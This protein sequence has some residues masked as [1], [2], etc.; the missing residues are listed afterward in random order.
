MFWPFKMFGGNQKGFTI[1]SLL[2]GLAITSI[3]GIGVAMATV[4]IM[5]SPSRVTEQKAV[6][7]TRIETV[8]TGVSTEAPP[9]R[10]QGLPQVDYAIIALNGDVTFGGSSVIKSD[11]AT[12]AE[13]DIYANGNITASGSSMAYGDADYTGTLTGESHIT[14]TKT[15]LSTALKFPQIQQSVYAARSALIQFAEA[16]GTHTGDKTINSNQN[17]GPIRITG[18]LTI[19]GGTIT[20]TGDVFVNGKIT[21]TGNPDI[22]GPY[23][24]AT[25]GD[26]ALQGTAKLDLANLP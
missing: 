2:G 8:Q 23:T 12:P 1:L 4:Q 21:M 25:D 16:G 19:T 15:Q 26:I 14:G 6:I 18:D 22:S 20:L 7:Q 13:G 9:T 11:P 5:K 24:I 3:V 10:L 17:L